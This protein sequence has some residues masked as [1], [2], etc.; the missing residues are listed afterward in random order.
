M[1][2]S[3]G[4]YNSWSQ[5]IIRFGFAS[6][7]DEDAPVENERSKNI[8][9][10]LAVCAKYRGVVIPT[11]DET[12]TTKMWMILISSKSELSICCSRRLASTRKLQ[13][14]DSRALAAARQA[15]FDCPSHYPLATGDRHSGP[16]IGRKAH[17]DW[18]NA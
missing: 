15:R 4:Q 10:M 9:S 12:N 1:T 11:S 16:A 7:R 14:G 18:H 13:N 2:E 17:R 3:Q 5:Q 8:V 6:L